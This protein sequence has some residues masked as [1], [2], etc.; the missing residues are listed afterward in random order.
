MDCAALTARAF[1]M[2]RFPMGYYRND[3]GFQDGR[4][5]YG[6]DR[7]R[8]DRGFRG[9]Y[10]GER[11]YQG[12][13]YQRAPDDRERFAGGRSYGHDRDRG[14]ERDR[15]QERGEYRSNRSTRDDRP[16]GYE[17]DDRGFFA[18]AGDE[19]RSWFGDEDA[20]RRREA[21]ARHDGRYY[22][23]GDFGRGLSRDHDPSYSHWRN[24]QIAS[25]DRDYDEYRRENQSHF[26]NQFGNWRTRRTDQR[27]ALQR[28]AEHMEV[29]GSDGGHVGTVDK[30]RGDRIVLTKTDQDAKG[31]HH[32][33][34]SSWIQAVDDR[35]TISRTA[36]EAQ[37]AWRDEERRGALFGDD[38]DGIGSA[39]YAYSRFVG[40]Y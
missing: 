34:P 38:P 21:D 15:H 39:S 4:R 17:Y 33:I 10:G 37:S 13:G 32:S 19:V 1:R 20:E 22:H 2:R 18:R 7:D 8:D 23:S 25:L 36:D 6:D 29:I 3:R 12:D 9:Y 26:D 28:V 16:T 11:G 30:V 27:S 40:F 24:R 35:V 14:Y 31:H 5:D